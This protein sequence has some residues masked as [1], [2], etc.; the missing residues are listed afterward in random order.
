MANNCSFDMRITGGQAE[1]KELVSMLHW[2]SL[3]VHP[4]LGRIFSIDA[5]PLEKTNVP[6][7]YFLYL[8]GDCAD[9]VKSSMRDDGVRY[10]SLESETKRL[11]L[12]VEVFS[13][14]PGREFQ[15]HVFI[16][17]GDVL[18]DDCVHYEE[19]FVDEYESLDGYNEAHGTNFTK[20]MVNCNG[21]V[22]IGGF[23]DDYA[24]F[25]DA[26]QYFAA[27]LEHSPLSV[28]EQISQ[29]AF[30]ACAGEGKQYNVCD[31]EERE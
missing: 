15:E 28:D 20:D 14:E 4:G 17:K 8:S 6:G 26:T 11:G 10:P 22:C 23:G 25:E 7:V 2:S 30:M 16:S 5:E 1:I 3:G 21:E 9:S 31:R 19:Y 27:E 18:V 12:V 13:S 29:A 24:N